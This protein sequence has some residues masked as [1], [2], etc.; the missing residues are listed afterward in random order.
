MLLNEV[1]QQLKLTAQAEKITVQEQQLH[2]M[3]LQLAEVKKLKQ[4]L[5][6]LKVLRFK[7]EA[8]C[9]GWTWGQTLTTTRLLQQPWGMNY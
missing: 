6:A 8:A 9:Q 2:D 4:Q 3:Q 5:A 1:Q 7:G